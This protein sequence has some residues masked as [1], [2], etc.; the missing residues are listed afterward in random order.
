MCEGEND[1]NYGGEDTV[2]LEAGYRERPRIKRN[3][4]RLGFYF[5]FLGDLYLG[6]TEILDNVSGISVTGCVH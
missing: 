6:K 1:A 4:V 3:L 2:R 5:F